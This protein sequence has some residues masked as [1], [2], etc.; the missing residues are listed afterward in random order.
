M[1]CNR[2]LETVKYFMQSE[3]SGERQVVDTIKKKYII[4]YIFSTNHVSLLIPKPSLQYAT[5]ATDSQNLFILSL[6]IYY[7]N[8]IMLSDTIL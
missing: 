7:N 3:V 2:M 1:L 5:T 4:T 6:H 8:S